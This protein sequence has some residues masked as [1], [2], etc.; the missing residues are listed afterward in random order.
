MVFQVIGYHDLKCQERTKEKGEEEA[1]YVETVY[2]I[3]MPT[4]TKS[5]PSVPT[6]CCDGEDDSYQKKFKLEEEKGKHD[7]VP[8]NVQSAFQFEG[9][10]EKGSKYECTA[11]WH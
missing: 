6:A 4:W 8:C 2:G 11:N 9:D 3:R 1:S 10:E 7:S 5:Q